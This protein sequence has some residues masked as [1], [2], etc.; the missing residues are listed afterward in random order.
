MSTRPKSNSTPLLAMTTTGQPGAVTA[1]MPLPPPE[2]VAG[3]DNAVPALQRNHDAFYRPSCL[4]HL[5]ALPLY[6][7]VAHWGWCT[8][9]VLTAAGVGAA[10]RLETR[11]A[12]AVMRYFARYETDVSFVRPWRGAIRVTALPPVEPGRK[13]DA[14]RRVA[15]KGRVR[16]QQSLRRWFLQRPNG[17]SGE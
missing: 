16:D 2:Q 11:R 1:A 4:S 13:T 17:A 12:Q 7:M 14:A 8:G 5:P 9:T 15:R 6:L 10:F 3:G